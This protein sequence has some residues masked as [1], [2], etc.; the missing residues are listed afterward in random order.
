MIVLQLKEERR[1]TRLTAAFS[2][3]DWQ[4]AKKT[5]RSSFTV[6]RLRQMPQ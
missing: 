1:P 5:Q 4:G 6:R 2:P 3:T